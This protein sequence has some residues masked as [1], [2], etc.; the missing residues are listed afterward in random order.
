MKKLIIVLF[1]V[2][3]LAYPLQA[4]KV[5]GSVRCE[6]LPLKGVIV[7]DGANFTKTDAAGKFKFDIKDD[8]WFVSVVT[9]AGYVA[10]FSS[11]APEFYLK[12]EGRKYF[13]FNLSKTSDSWDYTL[14]SVSDPQMQNAKHFKK[15]CGAPLKDLRAQA[16]KARIDGP[17]AGIALGDIAW[18]V[19]DIHREY[20]AAIISTGIPFYAVI[21]NHDFDKVLSGKEAAR[22]YCESFGPYNYAFYLGG[23]LV[24]GLKNI[25]YDTDKKYKEGYSEEE[26]AFVRGLLQYVPEPTH[27]YIAGHSPLYEW[28]RKAYIE[29]GEE[30][31][32]LLKGRK[33]DFLSGHTHI[34]NNIKISDLIM[35]HNAPS[36]C[37]AW[38]MTKWCRD[39]APRGYEIFKSR[40][41]VLSWVLHPIDFSEDFQI[42]IIAPG[43]C[44]AHPNAVVAN[45]WDYDPEWTVKWYQD[46]KDMG[47]MEQ[48][49]EVDPIYIREINKAYNGKEIPGYKKPKPNIH[50]FAAVPDQYAGTVTV[51][52]RSRFGLR[53]TYNVD[54]SRQ[55]DVQAH[56]GGAGLMPENTLSAMK[57]AIDLGVN[58]LEMDLQVSKDGKVVVSHDRY[59]HPRY[60][61]RPDGTEIRKEDPK[62]YLYTMP[63]D[64]IVKYDVGLRQSTVWPDKKTIAEVKPLASDLIDFVENYVKENGLS[65]MRYNIEIKST[66]GKGE[67]RNWP[68]YHE[69][70]DR[71]VELL[72]SKDLGSR[73]VVQCFDARALN[74]M[75]EKYPQLVLSYLTDEEDAKDWDVFMGKLNFTPEW[76]SPNYKAVDEA[77][78]RKCRENGIR[79]VPWT[80]DDPA[81]MKRIIGL[82]VDALIT[83]YP[84]RLLNITRGY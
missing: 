62:E 77:L 74:Y 8:A 70:V 9:P 42:N 13:S 18:D 66:Q 24:I 6:G 20:K 72:L 31:V 58:T 33:V 23:D 29:R 32:G 73:L 19:M 52:V 2:L 37:G 25:I 68:E 14:F 40:D 46:G 55:L 48:V 49:L 71:C 41:G 50:Y 27:I 7:T 47:R 76:L 30:L 4:R 53:W 28:W 75:H 11:G 26:L 82:G 83:N 59:F 44:K 34:Q 22:K 16:T 35:D 54:L 15:F 3:L 43:Q 80:C 36:I 21:G 39:G 63:Y 84:D 79:I 51:E 81:E 1:G 78:V 57:N 38:W 65:P 61:T 45:I 12:A 17:A 60:S 64:S 10:D 69:F 5:K 67:G 56:R